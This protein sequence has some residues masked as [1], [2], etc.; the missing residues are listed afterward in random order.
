MH[1]KE[2]MRKYKITQR[3]FADKLGITV[4]HLRMLMLRKG[5]P[6]KRLAHIIEEVTGGKITKE[7]ALFHEEPEEYR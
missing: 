3:A 5:S 1:L 4:T 2:F 7:E 6:S